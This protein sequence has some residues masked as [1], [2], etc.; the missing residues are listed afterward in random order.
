ME[1]RGLDD[2][3]SCRGGAG[4]GKEGHRGGQPPSRQGD[5]VGDVT[6]ACTRVF[7]LG[8]EKRP[9]S[10]G[11][12]GARSG[13]RGRGMLGTLPLTLKGGIEE[14]LHEK[15]TKRKHQSNREKTR[16]EPHHES[17]EKKVP[18]VRV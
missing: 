13:N 6:M 9:K 5:W 10:H 8:L 3:S 14:A 11:Q 7:T 2:I 15:E 17:Q 4:S 18:K 1:R 16:R 12:G